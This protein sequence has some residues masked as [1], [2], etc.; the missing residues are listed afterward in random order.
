MT[1]RNKNRHTATK[2]ALALPTAMQSD[3]FEQ[4]QELVNV[5]YELL[6]ND[7]KKII[8][9]FATLHP[10]NAASILQFLTTNAREEVIAVLGQHFDPEILSYLDES[11]LETVLDL[12]AIHEIAQKLEKLEGQ[13]ALKILEDLDKEERRAMLRALNPELRVFLEEGLA[14]PENSAG[15]LM[16][17]QVVA[18]PYEWTVAKVRTFLSTATNLPSDLDEI[19]IVNKARKPV[20]KISVATLVRESGSKNLKDVCE[21]LEVVF[22]ASENDK[23]VIFAFKT[24]FMKSAPVVDRNDKLIGVL[25]VTDIIDLIYT[26]AQEEFFHSGGLEESDFYDNL[27]ETARAR[28]KWLSF[29]IFGSIGVAMLIDT[30]RD[31]IAK[32]PT[33]AALMAIITSISSVASMQVVTI[34]I[35]ALVNRE[36]SSLNVKRTVLKE[37]LVALINGLILGLF[38]GAIFGLKTMDYRLSVVMLVS[39]AV[40]MIFSAIT[41]TFF[42]LLFSKLGIDPALSS[43]A[44]LTCAMDGVS[45]LTF[46]LIAKVMLS[47]GC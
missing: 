9:L 46:L 40:S 14:Y 5:V 2:T 18:V 47:G 6:D 31:I 26:E 36:L 33:I 32:Q 39:V 44:F 37:L 3:N 34:I 12:W 23:N 25:Q 20:A 15:R 16:Q 27:L 38:F 41:G 7:Q 29:S 45:A 21:N 43:G 13:D 10:A 30:F 4:I 35:R 28:L 19:F 11:V 8:E 17:H 22:K 24:Y 1:E 42:P